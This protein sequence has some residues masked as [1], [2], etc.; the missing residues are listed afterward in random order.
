MQKDT[1]HSKEDKERKLE[2]TQGKARAHV[3]NAFKNTMHYEEEGEKSP[4]RK[5]GF[6]MEKT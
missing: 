5:T 6:K 3:Q 4:K 1:T 2:T